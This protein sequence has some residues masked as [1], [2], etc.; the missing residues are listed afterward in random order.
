MIL[1]CNNISKSFGTDIIIKS[2]SFNIED[3][4]KA[5]IVGINGAGK[6]TLLKIITGEEPADTG[7]V[8]L[9]K[10]KTLGYLAQ[11]QDLQ[12]DR[13]IYDEL[14]SVKQ[15]I[16]DMESELRRIEAAMNSASGDELDALMNRY[17]NLNHE[18]EMN[19]GYAYKSEITG[20]L[21]GLGFTEE[22]FSLH[23]NTLSGG[24]KTRVSLGKLLLSKPDI[25][26]LDEPTN[27]L[28]MESISWLENYLLNYNGAVLIVAHDRYFLDKIVSK[29]IEIDNGDCTVFSGNYTDYASKKAILRNMKLKE[30]LNQ[31]RD[32]K[33][34]EAV[35]AKLKQFNREKSIKRAE[36]REKMLDKMEVVDKPVELN[37]KMNIQLEPSVVSGNDVLTVT[38]LTK[39]FDGNTLFNNINFDIKRGERVALIGNNGTGKTTILKLINGIIQ[40]DSGSIYLGAKVAIGY[41]DQEH[42]VLDPDKTLFQEIQDAYPDLNN[43][44]I[45]NTL[46][47]FLFTDDDV[48]KYIRDLSGGERGRVSLAKLM[49]SNANLLILDE[50]TNHLDIVSKEIL[51]NA[52]NS[53]TG[54]VLYVSHDRYFINATATRIIE[55]TNQNIV[56]YIGNYD[57]YL[58][59]RDILTTKTFPATTGSSSA[60]TAVKDSKI[61]WQ[62]SREEQNRLKKRKNEIKRT[63]ERISVVEERLSAIDAEYS[64]P[65]IGSNTARLMELHNES[66]GLQ[67]ELDELYEHWDSLMEEE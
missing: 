28:D 9:A 15:Y 8:T 64:D 44:Q 42:H 31:Q 27:H 19:N 43:T 6:S 34:Q 5:A 12:S 3:H 18:F 23:V 66:A 54:T 21:K 52:L 47:A 51:E 60:D 25:I 1:S 62:Q 17:T 48:F 33:H 20:V 37:A 35:I 26:M 50:P 14:L 10:D 46:A 30:Y 58:E 38:D 7:I 39:S 11:Q 56:N 2:C 40:P 22:D 65:S 67:K 32:I 24:Q 57:Y 29:I 61:S 45:R 13:S 53:Y 4:E 63:E 59:K 36:S 49:L 41:Y 16:L 55:L